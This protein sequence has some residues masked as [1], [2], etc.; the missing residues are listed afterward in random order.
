MNNNTSNFLGV[1][2]GEG[3]SLHLNIINGLPVLRVYNDND[4][5]SCFIIL[6]DECVI[7]N[8]ISQLIEMKEFVILKRHMNNGNK[9]I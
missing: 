6:Y 1:F 4:N 2:N 8:F 5:L 7:N 3:G 9:L